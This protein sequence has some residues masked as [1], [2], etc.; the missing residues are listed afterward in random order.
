MNTRIRA[1]VQFLL[2]VFIIE[3]V[4]KKPLKQKTFTCLRCG[5]KFVGRQDRCPRCGQL[6]VFEQ[7]GKFYNAIGDELL[8]DKEKKHIVKVIPNKKRPN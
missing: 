6:I 4:K 7:K 3:V 5:K 1:R 2:P 8:L